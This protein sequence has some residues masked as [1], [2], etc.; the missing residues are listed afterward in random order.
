[1]FVEDLRHNS[2]RDNF[3]CSWNFQYNI[4]VSET[5]VCIS[6]LG[7][8]AHATLQLHRL[9]CSQRIMYGSMQIDIVQFDSTNRCD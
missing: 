3:R 9:G 4:I 2:V 7:V 6:V 1:M 8:A 5:Y